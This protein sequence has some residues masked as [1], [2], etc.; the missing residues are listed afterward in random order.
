VAKRTSGWP[1]HS[2]VFSML[3]Q[4]FSYASVFHVTVSEKRKESHRGQREPARTR[5]HDTVAFLII[6]GR[7]KTYKLVGMLTHIVGSSF[8]RILVGYLVSVRS[9]R[10]VHLDKT[11]S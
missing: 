5:T 1:P 10:C 7:Q 6:L 11:G 9:F 8:P 2:P 3:S 4:Y